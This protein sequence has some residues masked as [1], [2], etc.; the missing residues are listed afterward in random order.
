MWRHRCKHHTV[1]P[2]LTG[3]GLIT[4]AASRRQRLI[5]VF[6]D[7]VHVLDADCQP[8]HIAGHTGLIQ[9]HCRWVVVAG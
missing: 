9:F 3:T 4:S 1:A 7:I 2:R 6:Q 5:D 8:D